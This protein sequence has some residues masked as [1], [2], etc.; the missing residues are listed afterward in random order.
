[1]F[2]IHTEHVFCI[3]ITYTIHILIAYRLIIL[4]TCSKYTQNTYS[5]RIHIT[6]REHI[7]NTN[8][9]HILSE[10]IYTV[11][12]WHSDRQWLGSG[13]FTA[14]R[15]QNV[16]CVTLWPC[17][18]QLGASHTTFWLATHTPDRMSYA[19]HYDHVFIDLEHH[20][21]LSDFLHTPDRMLYITRMTFKWYTGGWLQL[22]GSLH[23]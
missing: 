11:V 7:L 23:L 15:S 22:A 2:W 12:F 20:I 3:H 13:L 10:Y 21:W 8:A 17:V 18:D 9:L 14:W 4:N 1:M 6:Y 16:V 5:V 19:A